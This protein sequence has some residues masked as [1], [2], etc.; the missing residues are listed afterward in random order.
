MP[1][2]KALGLFLTRIKILLDRFHIIRE[3]QQQSSMKKDQITIFLA[4]S[5]SLLEARYQKL[6]FSFLQM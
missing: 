3:P 5:Q 2:L 6:G 1:A 4:Y